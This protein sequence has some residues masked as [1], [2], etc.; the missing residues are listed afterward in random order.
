MNSI[1][2]TV[3]ETS[4]VHGSI[5]PINYGSNEPA[6][7][8]LAKI[9]T[10]IKNEREK[11]VN[12][13]LVDNG[14][15]IQGTPLTYHYVRTN[16][17]EMNP[18]IKILNGL[19]YDAAVIGNHEFN[20]G[21]DVLNR[22]IEESEFP[23]LSAN[24]LDRDSGEAYFG[25]PYSILKVGEGVR[26]AIL[27]VTTHYIP[28]WENPEHIK[29]LIFE[30]ALK[31]TKEWVQKIKEEENPDVM[32]VSYHGGFE[33]DLESGE[34]TENQT[35]ENQGYRICQEVE[36]IDLLLTGHQHRSLA[37]K[38][39]NVPVLQ[40]SF[41]GQALGKATITLKKHLDRW[42]VE[43]SDVELLSVDS[44]EPDKSMIEFVKE[45]EENTQAWLDK[46]I[47]HVIGN[48][49]INDPLEARLK[50][51][52]LVEFI[53]KVQMDVANVSISNTALFNNVTKGFPENITMRDVVSNYIYPNTLSVV[54]ISGE[55][56]KQ[57]LERSASYFMLKDGEVT[58]NP[59][60][61]TPKPQH[62]N[63]DMWEGIEYI[64]DISK[65]IGN[66]VVKLT[67]NDEQIQPNGEY[68]V[69]MNNY[70]AGGGGDYV[71]FKDKPIVKDI[72]LDMSELIANYIL[73]R[74][75]IEAT[76]N[77]NWKVIW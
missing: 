34:P 4:D 12:T 61:T 14:D 48:M 21:M 18:M 44:I 36:G 6:E 67:F 75:T 77:N 72:P 69:V 73:E 11:N 63:Y 24:I 23:W 46:P 33:C 60:F 22:A 58:V 54:R 71:M 49:T 3:L 39:N 65:T 50:D 15:L 10:L 47:G 55:D 25:K 40:P 59:S 56:L 30:D 29:N 8:G 64:F 16:N 43:E 51:N 53:N 2:I 31:T 13:I 5:F 42:T 76:V 28:N 38:V 66:R 62:Y 57:A 37:G 1:T 52:A 32:I 27:G 26:V 41:N 17:T 7:L 9:A 45:Y 68:D 74:G 70:R 19:K 20:Y 35:G